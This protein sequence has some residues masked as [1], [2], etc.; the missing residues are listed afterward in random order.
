MLLN[1]LVIAMH[2]LSNQIVIGSK[3]EVI[4]ARKSI[5]SKI[6]QFNDMAARLRQ[7]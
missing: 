6:K 7:R 3:V 1:A 5:I 4:A 2:A